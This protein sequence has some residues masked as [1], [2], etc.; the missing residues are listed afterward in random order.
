MVNATVRLRIADHRVLPVITTALWSVDGEVRSTDGWHDFVQH[1]AGLLEIDLGYWELPAPRLD[2]VRSLFDRRSGD[3]EAAMAL[4]GDE[5]T[6]L[7]SDG[8]SGA[9]DTRALFDSVGIL[10]GRSRAVAKAR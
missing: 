3:L 9:A 1:S 7:F 5:Q 10:L 4:S 6:T 8:R 2:L